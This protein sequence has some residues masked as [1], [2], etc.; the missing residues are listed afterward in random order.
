MR[1]TRGAGGDLAVADDLRPLAAVLDDRVALLLVLPTRSA[2]ASGA[3]RRD[4]DRRPSRR[5]RRR[6]DR[7]RPDR[8]PVGRLHEP[9]GGLLRDARGARLPGRGRGGQ[10][11]RPPARAGRGRARAGAPDRGTD[12]G[13]ARLPELRRPVR[14]RAAQGDPRRRDGPREDHRGAGGAR[15]PVG[16]R[17]D[18][19]PRRLPAGCPGEL[20]ARD[21][22]PVHPHRASDPRRRVAG[23][24]RGVGRQR[25]GRRDDVRH[26]L[27]G[28]R[29]LGAGTADR[30]RRRR[31]GA[32]RQEPRGAAV[33]TDGR[34]GGRR[35]PRDP[36]HGDADAEPRRRVPDPRLL[37]AA[38]TA[39]GRGGARA[40]AVPASGRSG[41]PAS[42]PGGRARRAARTGGG[43]G[44]AAPRPARTSSPIAPGSRPGT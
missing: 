2:P 40:A 20:A 1:R 6:D 10:P 26:D 12:R 38:R 36:P 44:L 5:P 30:L 9:P 35:R 19:L 43:R 39:R 21:Q 14:P 15:A 17:C 34:A 28:V 41:V 23:G 33:A 29:R 25:R 13:A 3:R 24:G 27:D 31:R 42:Q 4:R 16:D 37:P 32:V 22:R 8:G 18:A 11:R 7:S